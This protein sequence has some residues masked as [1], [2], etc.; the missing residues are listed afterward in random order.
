MSY[1]L[2]PKSCL[3]K[4]EIEKTLS[5]S[6]FAT[7]YL[8]IQKP[9]NRKVIIKVIAPQITQSEGAIKRFEREAKIL[10]ELDDPG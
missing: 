8:A 5:R 3:S 10:S 6:H 9:L 1:Q 4:Y 7:V 2:L